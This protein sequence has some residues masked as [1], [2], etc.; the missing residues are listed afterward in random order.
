MEIRIFN[1]GHGFCAYIIAANRNVMLIDCG[2]NKETGFRPSSYLVANRCTGIERFIVSNYDED[3]VSDLHNLYRRLPIVMF[4]RNRSIDADELRRLK[5]QAGPIRPGMEALLDMHKTFIHSIPNPPEFPEIEMAA[6]CNQYPTFTD[7]NNLSFVTFLHY[8]NIHIVF[9]GDLEKAGWLTLL[10]QRAFQ[11]ELSRVNFFVAPH[12]G[13][14]NGYCAEVFDYCTPELVIIS[15]EYMH[16][17][18]QETEYRKH[19]SGIPWDGSRRYVLTTRN[20]GMITIS[21]R[22]GEGPRVYTAR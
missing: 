12:H 2:Y 20:D 5:L 11:E 13:R 9:P 19:A 22:P 3:H 15:D 18:T 21:Q 17:D 16:Y 4:H 10:R 1:V 7:T 8:H 14:E 6:F